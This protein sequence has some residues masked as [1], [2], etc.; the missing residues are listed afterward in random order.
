LNKLKKKGEVKVSSDNN[1]MD[2][3]DIKE[4]L[5][6]RYPFLMVDRVI[7]LEIGSR[8]KAYKMSPPTKSFSKG[9]SHISQL[10]LEY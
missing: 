6:Q 4:Y 3:E 2:V 10:C 8:I 1:I 9:I 7:E 5:P